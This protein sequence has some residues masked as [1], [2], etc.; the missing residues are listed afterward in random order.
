MPSLP[1]MYRV[2]SFIEPRAD[3]IC[4][5]YTT[6]S[7][8]IRS[9]N[10][11]P[12]DTFFPSIPFG[13]YRW[14]PNVSLSPIF[15]AF[16]ADSDPEDFDPSI[17]PTE[18][19]NAIE[20]DSFWCLS[21][22]L[23]GI[24]DNYIS[25]QP[26]IQRSVRRMAELVARIDGQCMLFTSLPLHADASDVKSPAFRPFRFAERGIYA[27]R[28]SMDEL[29]ADAGN[30]RPKYHQNVGHLPGEC[31]ALYAAFHIPYVNRLSEAE[32]P[33]AFSQFHLYVC[34]AFLVRW[35]DKLRQM[36]F[37][38]LFQ[39]ILSHHSA[40]KSCVEGI[41]MFLQSLPTQGWG[42]HEIEMLLSEAF[43]LNSIWQNAQSHFNAT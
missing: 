16:V 3:L 12:C 17:L 33:D 15:R 10:Q 25:A 28:I 1:A 34:S 20:A 39:L 40:H 27:I 18:V 21:R 23:D 42:D 22:L 8:W 9:G 41:I 30:Q 14:V 4:L 43:V 24:Q 31:R 38:V 37:Q 5:G 7:Q 19:L 6:S 11:R 36:D 35:S 29:S 13:V 32:G 2:R 26:G